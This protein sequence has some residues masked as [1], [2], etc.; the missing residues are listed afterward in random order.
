[1]DLSFNALLLEVQRRFAKVLPESV[2]VKK[3]FIISRSFRQGSTSEVQ[4]AGLSKEV[5]KAKNS[6][7]KRSR[8]KWMKPSMSMMEHYSDAKAD[9]LS[10][11]RF[12]ALLPGWWRN[13]SDHFNI[14]VINL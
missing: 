8:A 10:L 9:V 4:N 14:V 7:R 11:I 1:M 12:S 3:K 13:K 6:Q 5:I 2:N